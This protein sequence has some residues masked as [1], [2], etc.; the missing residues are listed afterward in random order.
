MK[1]EG[2]GDRRDMPAGGLLGFPVRECSENAIVDDLQ[3]VLRV[4]KD[5]AEETYE[6]KQVH[7]TWDM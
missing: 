3:D 2:P 5:V 6:F 1:G 4:G 7:H